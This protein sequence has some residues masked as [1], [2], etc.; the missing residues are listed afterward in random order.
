MVHRPQGVAAGE[1][2]QGC[3]AGALERPLKGVRG[4][5]VVGDPTHHT[6]KPMLGLWTFPVSNQAKQ[7]R[8]K[9]A[10]AVALTDPAVTCFV[11]SAGGYQPVLLAT[12]TLLQFQSA[13]QNASLRPR[14]SVLD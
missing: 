2:P 10:A 3:M 12:I 8:G 1:A 9:V 7:Q 4:S 11:R 5:G 6:L 14:V 13:Q